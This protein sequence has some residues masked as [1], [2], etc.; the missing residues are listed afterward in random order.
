MDQQ[1]PESAATA[2]RAVWGR[3]EEP[4]PNLIQ[5]GEAFGVRVL[6]LPTDA[7]TVDAFSLWLNDI[8]YVFLSTAKT[9]ERFEVGARARA[10]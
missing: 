10:F 1:D 2:L 7:D 9:A 8:P 5:L 3:G 4:L 6:S